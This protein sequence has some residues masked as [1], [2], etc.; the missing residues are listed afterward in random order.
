MQ[1]LI[2]KAYLS[3]RMNAVTVRGLQKNVIA[4]VKH[5]IGNEQETFRRQSTDMLTE[6]ISSN[7]DD[8]AMHEL[9]LWPF[10]D[11]VREG[12]ASVMCAYNKVRAFLLYLFYARLTTFQV[13]N[14]YACQ[15]SKLMNGLLKTELAFQGFVVSDWR[16]QHGGIA[17]A[18]SGLDMMMP[19]AGLWKD[20]ALM[21]AV[22][23]GTLDIS[24]SDDMATRILAAFY[25]LGMDAIHYPQ[26]GIGLPQFLTLPHQQVDA[27]D[28]SS[29]RSVMQAAVEGHVLVKNVNS[30]LPLRSPKLLSLFGFDGP[31]PRTNNPAAVSPNRWYFGATSLDISDISILQAV[32]TGTSPQAATLGTLTSGG[33]SGAS[34]GPYISSPFSAFDQKAW[35]DGIA[36]HWD[37][38]NENPDV[39]P[40]SDAC[41]VFIN[42]FS[43]EA[44]DR[45]GLADGVAD[46]LALNVASKCANTIVVVHNAGIRLVDRWI[47]HTN[48]KAVI[49][50]HLPGQDSGRAL[51]EILFGTKSPSGRL[52]YTVAKRAEDY[53]QLLR[54]SEPQSSYPQSEHRAYIARAGADRDSGD[55][56]ESLYIDYRSFLR[57]NIEPRFAFGFGLSYTTFDYSGIE[58]RWTTQDLPMLPPDTGFVEGGL[59]SLFDIVAEVNFQVSNNGFSG[60]AEVAQLYIGIPNAPARQLRGFVKKH[61]D[62]GAQ[63]HLH[64]GLARR[65][66]S[67][68]D[69]EKQQWTLQ[70]GDYEL[71]V[72]RSVLDTLLQT[73]LSL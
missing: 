48:V 68:W 42:E 2:K 7:I 32:G 73:R 51:V 33:G 9:Y 38:H 40:A 22:Q 71:F 35:E 43:A 25:L 11:A 46:N 16:A 20:Q 45:P 24:R 56:N 65:D 72:G 47:E 61:I 69:T 49:F 13:N 63:V 12:V 66:M 28:R 31:A 44:F 30:T 54:P 62:P 23:N 1:L 67:I 52:P 58:A 70:R 55:F 27:R 57:E 60:A 53:G 34:T 3:G 37:F 64:L 26:S 10:Q 36:L 14:S 5:L 6:G 29:R 8:W 18:L 4:C 19:G 17:A 41:I 39:N 15:N 59:S 50:A 21:K